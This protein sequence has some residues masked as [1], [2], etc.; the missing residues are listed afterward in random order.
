[1]GLAKGLRRGRVTAA[2][3]GERIM[4][5]LALSVLGLGAALALTGCYEDTT[6]TQYEP[7]VYKGTSDPLR[8]KLESQEL[9]DQLDERFARVAADR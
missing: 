3:P 6:P 8:N 5:R 7:G 2:A 1:M 9:R 4:R